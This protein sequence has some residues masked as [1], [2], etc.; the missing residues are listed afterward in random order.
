[1]SIKFKQIKETCI[2]VKDLDSIY[3]FYCKTLELPVIAY[4]KDKHLFLRVGHSV[5]LFFNPDDSKKKKSPPSH[6]AE[7]KQHFAFEVDKA[8]YESTKEQIIKK[9]IQITEEVTWKS[10]KKSFYFEDPAENVLEIV[11]DQGIWD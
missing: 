5:L 11:P 1:V 10:G 7:G 9:G 3:D 4:L 6:Y 2:Y 8:D